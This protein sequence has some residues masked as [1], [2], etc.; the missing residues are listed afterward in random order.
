MPPHTYL[1]IKILTISNADKDAEQLKYPY[2][3]SDGNTKWYR[4]IRKRFSR[5]FKK[6]HMNL[7]YGPATPF[8]SIYLREMNIYI[9]MS[10]GLKYNGSNRESREEE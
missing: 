9:Y 5:I 10:D 2:T 4:H 8:L 6:L 1:K 7:S 3:A